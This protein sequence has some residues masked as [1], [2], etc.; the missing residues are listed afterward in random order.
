M[1]ED[2][3]TLVGRYDLE[4]FRWLSSQAIASLHFHTI[5]MWVDE[6]AHQIYIV[7]KGQLL[8]VPLSQRHWE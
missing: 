8:S 5:D 6:L 2:D 3:R 1:T 4:K 7:Y